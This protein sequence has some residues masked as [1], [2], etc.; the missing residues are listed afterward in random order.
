MTA[1][2]GRG[3]DFVLN[4]LSG[5]LLHTSWKCVAAFGR[6]VEIGKRDVIGRA[7]LDLGGFGDNGVLWGRPCLIYHLE[8][9]KVCYSQLVFNAQR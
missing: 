6:M 3:V 9:T 2:E 1:T 4:S 7:R 5:E 8:T